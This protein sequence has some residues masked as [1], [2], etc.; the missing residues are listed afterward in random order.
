[1]TTTTPR[2]E[3]DR[4]RKHTSAKN[5]ESIEQ[6]IEDSI[7]FY[8]TQPVAAIT[9][10]I[11]E[12]EWEWSIERW[13]ETNASSLAFSGIVLGLTVSRKWFALPLLV[14]GFLFQ[15]AIH[16]WCPPVPILRRMGIR[17]RSEID[18]EKFAL[19]VIRGDFKDID[20]TALE[21]PSQTKRILAAVNA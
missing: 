3:I 17:T 11:D 5:L 1:M 20:S 16:G 2:I 21:Q 4:V 12:L 14:T 18:R 10:R 7:R 19:K 8:A 15:H 6:Q 9:R 13:L